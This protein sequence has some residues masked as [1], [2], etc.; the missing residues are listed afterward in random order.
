MLGDGTR[1][2]DI[3]VALQH[4]GQPYERVWPYDKAT[5]SQ[6]WM[7]PFYPGHRYF[8]E[9]VYNDFNLKHVLTKLDRRDPVVISFWNDREFEDPK[10]VGEYSLIE[11]RRE[12][13]SSS[14]H[15]VLAVG[16]GYKNQTL[17][18]KLRNS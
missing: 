11:Q 8:A 12:K 9:G 10:T 5:K 2:E 14:L 7:P 6:N 4:H 17:Y 1:V 3:S 18:V 15:A 16:Y 13:S